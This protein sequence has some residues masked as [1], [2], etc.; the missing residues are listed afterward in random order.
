MSLSP[1]SLAFKQSKTE[2]RTALLTYTVASDPAN[3]KFVST[4]GGVN[5]STEN[6]AVKVSAY[7]TDWIDRNLTKSVQTGQ[8]SSGDTD[9]IFL[10][11]INQ[12][13]Q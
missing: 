12:K 13:H 11:G 3:E 9:V 10:S 5:F 7:N 2:G 4:E 1:I 6:V 8:G